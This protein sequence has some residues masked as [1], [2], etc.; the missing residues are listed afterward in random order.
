[1]TQDTV[2]TVQTL[3]DLGDI[4]QD[5]NNVVA[6]ILL[7]CKQPDLAADVK[8]VFE[9][10][11]TMNM[12]QGAAL[13]TAHEHSLS[14][15]LEDLNLLVCSSAPPLPIIA[16][17]HS[18][19]MDNEAST[20]RK[21]VEHVRSLVLLL[22][23]AS[24][25]STGVADVVINKLDS[26]PSCVDYTAESVTPEAWR[27]AVGERSVL[28]AILRCYRFLIEASPE[29]LEAKATTRARLLAKARALE[30]KAALSGIET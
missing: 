2:A 14:G 9:R 24:S 6:K 30:T 21:A 12:A 17:L 28:L 23:A 20:R 25:V 13:S 5:A 4:A 29:A 7:Q 18:M 1:M 16:E 10:L 15:E 19:I 26:A 3:A 27:H 8:S 22:A 11:M